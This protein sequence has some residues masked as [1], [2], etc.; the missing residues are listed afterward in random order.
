MP[1]V[2][3]VCFT[4]HE[5]ISECAPAWQEHCEKHYTD[6]I[7]TQEIEN[8]KFFQKHGLDNYCCRNNLANSANILEILKRKAKEVP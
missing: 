8:Q 3:I 7:A 4:C 2:P 1:I 5:F 6:P